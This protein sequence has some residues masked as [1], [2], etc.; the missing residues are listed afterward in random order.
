MTEIPFSLIFDNVLLSSLG[1]EIPVRLKLLSDAKVNI[2]SKISSFGINNAL[3][4]LLLKF[5]FEVLVYIPLITKSEKIEIS[6]P[7][8]TSLIEGDVPSIAFGE[9]LL[10]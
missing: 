5:E 10:A 9:Q 6:I 8:Y 4:E 7:I 2:N 1:P 3:V